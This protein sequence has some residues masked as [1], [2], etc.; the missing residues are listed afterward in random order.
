MRK[1]I[2]TSLFL[3]C[4]LFAGDMTGWISDAAC[5]AGN[6]NGSSASRE[7]AKNCIKGGSKAVFVSE[8]DQKVYQLSDPAKAANFLDKKVKVSGKVSGDKIELTSIA[9]AE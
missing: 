5:G 6:G 2:C 8:K 4:S 7:C 3:G 1:L 9:Y